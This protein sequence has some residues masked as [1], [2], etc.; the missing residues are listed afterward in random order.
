MPRKQIQALPTEFELM[1]NN[2][3]STI[4][5]YFSTMSCA[6]CGNQTHKG[7]CD[8]CLTKPQST[9]VALNYKMLMWER[10][11]AEINQVS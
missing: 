6:V 10:H 1:N 5:Q 11:Q 2:K 7:L 3:K 4:S 8:V 9:V